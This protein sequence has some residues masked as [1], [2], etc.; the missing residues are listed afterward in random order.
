[1]VWNVWHDSSPLVASCRE[2]DI[3]RATTWAFA[4]VQLQPLLATLKNAFLIWW[5]WP[6]TLNF[7]LNL[8]ILPLDVHAEIQVRVSVRLERR[9]VTHTMS[10]LLHPSLMWGV[11]IGTLCL[12]AYRW[13]MTWDCWCN[14]TSKNPWSTAS[15]HPK[16]S[17]CTSDMPH[18]KIITQWI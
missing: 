11:K 1:M 4:T 3:S 17:I 5:P 6:L 16:K 13:H 10:K 2:D 12:G 8:H 9:V 7:E 14:K 18:C 15:V